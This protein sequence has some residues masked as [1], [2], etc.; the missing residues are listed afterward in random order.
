[1]LNF[2]LLVI[3]IS[4]FEVL[5]VCSFSF[6]R[7]FPHTY[8]K[9]PLNQY[10]ET[11]I[12]TIPKPLP[13]PSPS[14]P[15]FYRSVLFSLP[16]PQEDTE[17]LKSFNLNSAQYS[18]GA[19]ALQDETTIATTNESNTNVDCITATPVAPNHTKSYQ[20]MHL[21]SLPPLEDSSSLSSSQIKIV[22]EI[23]K[24]KDIVLGDGRDY[25]IPRPRALRALSQILIRRSF[26]QVLSLGEDIDGS[27]ND[28][29][30][31]N[32]KLDA[33]IEE[34]AILSNCARMD[35]LLYVTTNV[36]STNTSDDII[37]KNKNAIENQVLV[38]TKTLVSNCLVNQLT[39]YQTM[40][41]NGKEGGTTAGPSPMNIFWEG[42]SSF[43]DLPGM[44][45]TDPET[46]KSNQH[47]KNTIIESS[48]DTTTATTE[49][50]QTLMT[51]LECSSQLEDILSHF[52]LVAAGLA[53]RNSR[54]GRPVTFRPFSSRDAHIMLQLKR[55]VEVL[56]SMDKE[57]QQ[58]KQQNSNHVKLVLECA[59][60]A[61]K[62]ARDVN[63]VPILAQLKK[64]DCEGKYSTS[65][66]TQ[67]AAKAIKDVKK[68]AIQPAIDR[69]MDKLKSQKYTEQI[70]R[71]KQQVDHKM[72]MSRQKEGECDSKRHN[73]I[74]IKQ[75]VHDT[76]V[77][78]RN[79]DD[80][81]TEKILSQIDVE[82]SKN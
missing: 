35:V 71:F 34:C 31:N 24:W 14:S 12:T 82:L 25:F 48:S 9:S 21:I 52:C 65:A 11:T 64:Y 56:V 69:C 28:N 72:T 66:P 13:S 18:Q 51:L 81:D 27:G 7:I 74:L 15:S 39:L 2:L 44:V 8:S 68:L 53:K 55:T 6:P 1:M 59:L 50:S 47:D 62:A 45:I 77:E 73:S 26:E 58:D 5:V 63:T 57:Q 49:T 79:G 16:L 46:N 61:G 80:I 54:P 42:I 40:R 29:G 76:I 17:Q 70:L 33:T 4:T 30:K 41:N 67:L 22:K 78:L 38:A 20:S 36:T 19:T 75:M 32:V 23:W 60:S 43:L 10:H 37:N 3:L